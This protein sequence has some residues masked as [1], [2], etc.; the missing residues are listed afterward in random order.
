VQ[1]IRLVRLRTSGSGLGTVV[2]AA[3]LAAVLSAAAALIGD[4][5]TAALVT[6]AVLIES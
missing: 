3:A 5:L 1:A 2:L 4:I 6:L